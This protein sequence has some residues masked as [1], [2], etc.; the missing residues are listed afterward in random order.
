[1]DEKVLFRKESRAL[2]TAA[3][4]EDIAK[5]IRVFYNY[6]RDSE[7]CELLWSD[8]VGYLLIPINRGDGCPQIIHRADDLVRAIVDEISDEMA[9]NARRR[10]LTKR[11]YPELARYIR[12][13]M[14][15]LP[16]YIDC[17]PMEFQ[18]V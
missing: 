14:V 4:M 17:L 10:K 9:V 6:L 7:R 15:Q 16:E 8:K 2:Y 11:E 13:Y 3:E 1:M 5:V 12:D 18:A